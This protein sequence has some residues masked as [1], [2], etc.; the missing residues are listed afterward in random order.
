MNH[1]FSACGV[2]P[3]SRSENIQS[4]TLRAADSF[5]LDCGPSNADTDLIAVIEANQWCDKAFFEATTAALRVKG[6]VLASTAASFE[7][8]PDYADIFDLVRTFMP[9]GSCV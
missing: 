9:K 7:G 5:E 4:S 8:E 3:G 1:P 2:G 6:V